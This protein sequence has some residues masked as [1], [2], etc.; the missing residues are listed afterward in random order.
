MEDTRNSAIRVTKKRASELLAFSRRSK[1]RDAVALTKLL[2]KGVH[3]KQY[4]SL[5]PARPEQ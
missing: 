1:I 3:T 4:D 2:K 5:T